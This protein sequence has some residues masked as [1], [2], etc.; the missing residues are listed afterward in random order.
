[1]DNKKCTRCLLTKQVS[2]FP[3]HRRMRD[4]LGK[5]C[6]EC[7]KRNTSEN[8]S[9]WSHEQILRSKDY[10]RIW[11][12]SPAGRASQRKS[13][14]KSVEYRRNYGREFQRRLRKN[15]KYFL[16]YAARQAVRSALDFGILKKPRVCQ[17]NGRYGEKCR[18]FPVEGHHHNGYGL[19]HWLD[20]EWLCR[21]C[22]IEA[23]RR[24]KNAAGYVRSNG[25]NVAKYLHPNSVRKERGGENDTRHYFAFM[26]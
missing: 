15:P 12:Q 8:R 24:I 18:K 7:C 10:S 4:G 9:K 22:H 19:E 17:A 3:K 14:K 21:Y 1:M 20:V 6:K 16:R 11:A 13:A 5:W 26:A 25:E 2:E 23:D